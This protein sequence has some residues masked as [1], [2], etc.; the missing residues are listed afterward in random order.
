MGAAGWPCEGRR[1]RGCPGLDTTGS[2]GP[3]RPRAEQGWTLQPTWGH[4]GESGVKKWEKTPKGA[5][6]GRT[7]L[8]AGRGRRRCARR[9]GRAPPAVQ[10]PGRSR[11]EAGRRREERGVVTDWPQPPA[12]PEGRGR[13]AGSEGV[14]LSL[15]RRGPGRTV[16]ICLYVLLSEHTLSGN[17]LS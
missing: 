5:Q 14:K 7:A 16:L 4:L 6:S 3:D 11:A 9:R 8:R 17:K 13:G 10:P 12:P 15:W 2:T 1:G